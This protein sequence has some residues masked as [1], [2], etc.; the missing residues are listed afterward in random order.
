MEGGWQPAEGSFRNLCATT[1]HPGEKQDHLFRCQERQEVGVMGDRNKGGGLKTSSKCQETS[2][3]TWPDDSFCQQL[4]ETSCLIPRAPDPGKLQHGIPE[5]QGKVRHQPETGHPEWA[6]GPA[7]SSLARQE[8]GSPCWGRLNAPREASY[9]SCLP[10]PQS[11]C[12][13]EVGDGAGLTEGF[14]STFS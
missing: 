12:R 10:G 2:G 14:L 11:S 9:S 8:M 5:T 7:V 3:P 4:K 6:V 1:G 13:G